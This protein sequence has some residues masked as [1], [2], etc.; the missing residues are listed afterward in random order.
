MSA[1]LVPS[2]L[3]SGHG[4][5]PLVLLHG[6]GSTASIWLPQLE[7]F[8][9]ERLTV[10]WTMPGYGHSP[11]AA[12]IDWADL[13]DALE[14]MR[15]ALRIERMHLLGHSIGGM[16]AQEYIH[17]HPQRVASLILSA[18]TAGFGNPD[19]TWQQEFV[20]LRAEPL[21]NVARF[22][23]AAPE[24]L[25]KF[26]GADTRPQMFRL[27]ELSADGVVKSQYLHYMR[28]LTT[29]DRKA[30]LSDI[31]V[32]TL[33]MAGELDQQAPVKAM[34]RMAEHL[35]QVELHEFAHI[36][37]MANIESPDRFN[38]TVAAFLAAAEQD[39]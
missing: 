24:L 26:V 3:A 13:A 16:V 9:R 5:T 22:G 28:L 8:G 31:A 4:G 34:R 2:W 23:D 35:R 33:L 32:P 21:A 19:L 18:T 27:A 14:A 25:R 11:A 38:H 6:M 29:F 30:A 15:V 10:A 1:A 37:H 36:N 39:K 17:R 7:H 12:D 20:R